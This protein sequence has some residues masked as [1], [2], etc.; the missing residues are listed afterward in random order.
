MK[1][2][3]Y[4]SF[5]AQDW[6]Y[7]TRGHSDFQL[8]TRVAQH[9]PVLFIN[10]LG[11][12]MPR[13]GASSTPFARM[14]RKLASV[15]RGL[16]APLK[17]TPDF[18]VLTPLF[19]PVYGD[20][21]I[22]RLNGWLVAT[23][24]RAAMRRIGI[25]RPAV[26]VTLPTAWPVARRLDRCSTIVYRSDR[27]S[28]LP[29]ADTSVVEALERDMLAEADVA[30]FA[31]S[32][33]LEAE[34]TSTRRPVLLRH[35]VDL[36]MFRPAAELTAHQ[37]LAT[38]GTPRVGFVGI[39]DAYTVDTRLLETIAGKYP[40]RR[41]RVGRTGGGG[42]RRTACAPKRASH[43]VLP[44]EEVPAFL[45][46]LDVLLMPWQDNEWIKH[47]NP[48]KLKEYLAV[49]RPVLSTDFPEARG[50]VDVID[51]AHDSDEFVSMLGDLLSGRSAGS[52]AERRAVAA[53]ETWDKQVEKLIREVSPD[54]M[55]SRS[56]PASSCSAP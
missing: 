25:R 8:M 12:R 17:D 46:G 21:F 28:A 18:H 52:P 31:S 7:F 20:G 33:L 10:S 4:V 43:G 5:S 16:K 54:F 39:I 1:P 34:A 9:D 11:M 53:S 27:Y 13:P 41:V 3:G 47:C 32:A 15:A 24:V 6:W 44:F 26:V 40:R 49:G 14:G 48:I 51:I 38:V 45:A 30:L 56:A 2:D 55:P 50:Y 19:L 36:D 37:R 22:S 35:G 42:P 23:Q 29:E